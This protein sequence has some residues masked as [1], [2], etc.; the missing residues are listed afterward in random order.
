MITTSTNTQTLE[1]YNKAVD[2]ILAFI[3]EL[4]FTTDKSFDLVDVRDTIVDII[5]T[6]TQT[7]LSETLTAELVEEQEPTDEDFE[8]MMLDL[9]EEEEQDKVFCAS[10]GQTVSNYT[11]CHECG[12]PI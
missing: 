3:D 10:C 1:N 12:Q 9:Q 11:V 5:L 2:K 6:N 8:Q 7:T 4:G